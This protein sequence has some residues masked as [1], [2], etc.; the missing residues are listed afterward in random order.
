VDE[1]EPLP[2]GQ[3]QF[4]SDWRR[5]LATGDWRCPGVDNGESPNAAAAA[6]AAGHLT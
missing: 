4:P 5:G 6:A 3:V 2:R 1:C